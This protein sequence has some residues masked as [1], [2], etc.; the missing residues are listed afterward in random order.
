MICSI[1]LRISSWKAVNRACFR[2][3]LNIHEPIY[4]SP[5][6]IL[7]TV[8]WFVLKTTGFPRKPNS[9]HFVGNIHILVESWLDFPRRCTIMICW[10]QGS[11]NSIIQSQRCY[12][13]SHPHTTFHPSITRSLWMSIRSNRKH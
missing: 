1:L 12:H 9:E 13:R 7:V 3:Y 4:A 8:T 6:F 10:V 11:F 5:T 2:L